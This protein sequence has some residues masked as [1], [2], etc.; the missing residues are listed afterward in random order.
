MWIYKAVCNFSCLHFSNS[1]IS[2]IYW[3]MFTSHIKIC[4]QKCFLGNEIVEKVIA[5]VKSTMWK[6]ED[7]HG[8]RR[9][10]KMQES[11]I[12]PTQ[13]YFF[14]LPIILHSC[15][16]MTRASQH[17][18]PVLINMSPNLF[19]PP[20]CVHPSYS[21]KLFRH[22]ISITFILSLS[23]IHIVL[24]DGHEKWKNVVLGYVWWNAGQRESVG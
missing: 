6:P 21:Y 1:R 15:V 5:W 20:H 12:L 10:N 24:Y 14:H 11:Q 7:I 19:S 2:V 13:F 18:L 22:L 8:N 16:N 17:T 9:E 23:I 4:K 3:K